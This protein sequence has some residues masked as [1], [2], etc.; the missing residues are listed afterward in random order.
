[1]AVSGR[2]VNPVGVAE[3]GADAGQKAMP[4]LIGA[5][6][7]FEAHLAFALQQAEFDARGVCREQREV[8]AI[9][10]DVRTEWPGPAGTQPRGGR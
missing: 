10:F 2:A 8:D 9:V 6:R 1:M 3:S 4:D 5:G 7:K